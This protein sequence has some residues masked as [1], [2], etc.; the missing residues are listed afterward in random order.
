ME[1]LSGPRKLVSLSREQTKEVMKR[2]GCLKDRQKT[3]QGVS[4]EVTA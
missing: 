1:L 4:Y 2:L 3:E